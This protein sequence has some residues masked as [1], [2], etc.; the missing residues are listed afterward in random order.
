MKSFSTA[1]AQVSFLKNKYTHLLTVLIFLFL[2]SP[3]LEHLEIKFPII[4]ST[5]LIAILLTLRALNLSKKVFLTY[6]LV[7]GAALCSDVI[8]SSHEMPLWMQ[9]SLPLIS[10]VIYTVFLTMSIFLLIKKIFSTEKVSSDTIKGGICIYLLIGF[11]W[12]LLY[13]IVTFFNPHAFSTPA[14]Q[15]DISL[16]YFSFVT[17][18]TVGYGDIHPISKMAMVLS[19][20][21][22]LVGQLYLAI[23][24][25]RL[26][27]LHIIHEVNKKNT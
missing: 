19:N 2:A 18:T 6:V 14:V 13:Y 12:A 17:L 25:A 9:L 22:A 7:G 21:E 8:F 23:F 26:V 24:I 1:K 16:F 20:M 10:P 11:L 15:D 4:T 27:G 3:F 5:F